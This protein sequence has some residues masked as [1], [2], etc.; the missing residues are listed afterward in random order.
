[1]TGTSLVLIPKKNPHLVDFK[2][3][4]DE[5]AILMPLVEGYTSWGAS[6]TWRVHSWRLAYVSLELE[7]TE[8]QNDVS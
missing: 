4:E 1:V 5:Q 3:N 2:C 8:D 6:G 7:D